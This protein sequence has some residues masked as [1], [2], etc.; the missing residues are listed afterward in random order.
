MLSRSK[1]DNFRLDRRFHEANVTITHI[2]KDIPI[3]I[4][5]K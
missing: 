2:S 5:G 3:L 4:G 1:V